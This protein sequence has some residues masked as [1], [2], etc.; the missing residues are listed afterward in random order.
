MPLRIILPLLAALCTLA[1]TAQAAE[2][3]VVLPVAL[4][5]KA[6]IGENIKR[7]CGVEGSIAKEVF[8]KVSERYPGAE[9]NQGVDPN[10]AEALVLNVTILAVSGYGGGGW[11]GSKSIYIQAEVLRKGRVA[12]SRMFNRASKG[13]G[14]I[15]GTCDIMDRIAV[16]L[17]QDVGMWLHG[18]LATARNMSIAQPA[19]VETKP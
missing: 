14:G 18:A 8:Q 19:A 12:A 5:P 2:R 10:D 4:A 6:S 7:E 13:F 11:S 15:S 17:G 1:G 16:A 9:Q 3:L